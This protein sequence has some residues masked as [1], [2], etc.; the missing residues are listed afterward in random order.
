MSAYKNIINF[1]IFYPT[2]PDF[3][4]CMRFHTMILIVVCLLQPLLSI[5]FNLK[6]IF[7]VNK[8]VQSKGKE[9]E[10]ENEKE[11]KLSA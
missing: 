10:N 9:N 4:L 5:E 6:I 11:S 8:C 7:F 1:K 3:H 2:G